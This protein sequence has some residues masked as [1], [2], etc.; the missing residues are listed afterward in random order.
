MKKFATL[1]A[2]AILCIL[3]GCSKGLS[4][5]TLSKQEVRLNFVHEPQTIDPRKGCDGYSS[6][7]QY[8]LFE[9]LTKPTSSNRIELGLAK[10]IDVSSDLMTY[11]FHLKESYWS[12]GT[13]LTAHDFVRT[14][15]QILSPIFPSPNANL[16][17]PIRNAERAKKGLCPLDEVGIS[18]I[19]DHTLRVDLAAPTTQFLSRTSFPAL[20]PVHEKFAENSHLPPTEIDIIGNGPFIIEEW[21]KGSEIRLRKNPMYWDKSSVKLQKIHIYLFNHEVTAFRMYENR[22]LDL[23]GPPLSNIPIDY[24]PLLKKQ[25]K[26]SY[27]PTATTSLCFFNTKAFP[28]TNVNIRKAFSYAINKQSIIEHVTHGNESVAC[29]VVPPVLKDDGQPAAKDEFNI[30]KAK[31]HFN[32]GL[33]ELNMGPGDFDNKVTLS[34]TNCEY[35]QTLAYLLQEMWFNALGIS[36][37]LQSGSM[38]SLMG[39]FQ[40][41]DFQIAKLDWMSQY[42]DKINILEIF[43]SNDNPMNFTG[44]ENSSLTHLIN[45][46]RVCTE[47]SRE[48]H[49]LNTIEHILANEIPAVPLYH[50]NLVCMQKPYLRDVVISPTGILLFH[51]AYIDEQKMMLSFSGEEA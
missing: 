41:K 20:Y 40:Q 37:R 32:L 7:I 10:K 47:P 24:I 26:L 12:D 48:T 17:Y 30:E 2:I 5:S 35:N 23:I 1:A 43:S 15:K 22:E 27:H 16:F 34:F 38:Q 45:E 50:K 19:D 28:F 21:N 33:E 46:L 49:L 51:H 4:T 9:G 36:V 31:Y 6:T 25:R 8:M 42:C 44:W 39:R 29:G 14:W 18:A 11:T 3:T 13:P